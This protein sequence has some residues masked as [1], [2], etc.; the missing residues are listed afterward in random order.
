MAGYIPRWFTRPVVVTHPSTNQARRSVTTAMETATLA[1]RKTGVSTKTAD[2]FNQLSTC[3]C[4]PTRLPTIGRRAFLVVGR[5]RSYLERPTGRCHL[6]TI[7]A[8]LQK[9]TK[10]ASVSTFIPWPNFVNQLL[11]CVVLVVA[12]CYLV[13]PP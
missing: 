2:F 6:S 9:T 1:L 4:S 5:R 8:H 3:S 10:T 13:R 11:L 12:A 7:S